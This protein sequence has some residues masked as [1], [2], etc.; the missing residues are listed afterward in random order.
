MQKRNIFLPVCYTVCI[1][2]ITHPHPTAIDVS[3][4]TIEQYAEK[5][6]LEN[7]LTVF[8]DGDSVDPLFAFAKKLGGKIEYQ[9]AEGLAK[10]EH[11]S[12][13]VDGPNRFTIHLSKFTGP[14]RDRFTVA[15][16][17]G[18]YFLHSFQGKKPIKAYR[19]E[20]SAAES[21]ADWFAA[22][23][24]MPERLVR[25]LW[26]N[27]DIQN[28]SELAARFHTSLTAAQYRLDTLK[29]KA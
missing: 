15:H 27:E 3:R 12:I 8:S 25:E 26:V 16:E 18:H 14:M 20:R 29:L 6:A 2:T 23:L 4:E 9:D 13:V 10:S 7:A 5:I 1:M 21:Q 24:L 19:S 17:L 11:G 28:A 22:S